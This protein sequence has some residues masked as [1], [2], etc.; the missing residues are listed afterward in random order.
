M[1]LISFCVFFLFVISTPELKSVRQHYINAAQSKTSADSFYTSLQSIEKG[2]D[3]TLM[4]YKAAS[5]VL[6]AKYEKGIITKTRFFNRGT[7][8]LEATIEKAPDNYEARLIRLN[9]QDNVPWITGYKSEIK[10]DKAFLI[11]NYNKQPQ[12]LKDF[13]KKYVKQSAAFSDEEKEYFN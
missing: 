7:D 8:M 13:T 4:A 5:V 12:D 1:K 3:A 11:K 10:E 9:I 6:M 2:Q